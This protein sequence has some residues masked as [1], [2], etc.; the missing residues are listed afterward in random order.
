MTRFVI[1]PQWQGSPS[2][3]AMA[4]ADGA[5][6]ICGDLPRSAVVRVE[7][8]VEAGESLNSGVLRASSLHKVRRSIADVLVSETD[9]CVLIGG[10]CSIAVAGIDH[11]N[12]PDLAVIWFDAHADLNSTSTSPSG[13]FAGMAARALLGDVPSELA[14]RGDALPAHRL[15]VAGS[16]AL[17]DDEAVFAQDSAVSLVSVDD[18]RDPATLVDAVRASGATRIYIHIDLD[19]LDPA[20]VT[21]VQNPMPFGLT[22][23]ELTAMVVALRTAFDLSGASL[24]GF[25]PSTPAAAVEDLGTILRIVGAL[26]AA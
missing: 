12:H 13:A 7:V 3:R 2:S 26:A 16:R 1:V 5:E 20:H 15:F 9:R 25:A 8:P 4:L 11:V 6:A 23:T 19:V 22:P 14:L 21:G 17:D 24:A 18:L 10:D